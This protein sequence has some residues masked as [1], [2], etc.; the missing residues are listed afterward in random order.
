MADLFALVPSDVKLLI[1]SMT[2]DGACAGAMCCTNKSW[3]GLLKSRDAFWEQMFRAQVSDDE[4]DLALFQKLRAQEAL[5]GK[6]A[7]GTFYAALCERAFRRAAGA[8]VV[9]VTG[10]GAES[11]LGFA[12]EGA[13][14]EEAEGVP[15]LVSGK[16]ARVTLLRGQDVSYLTL[17]HIEDASRVAA[18][19]AVDAVVMAALSGSPSTP[20]AGYRMPVAVLVIAD[21]LS[22]MKR[23]DPRPDTELHTRSGASVVRLL[24]RS[25]PRL[26]EHGGCRAQRRALPRL[27]SAVRRARQEEGRIPLREASEEGEEEGEEAFDEEMRLLEEGHERGLLALLQWRRPPQALVGEVGASMRGCQLVDAIQSAR[28]LRWAPAL[29]AARE[30]L[31][32]VVAPSRPLLAAHIDLPAALWQAALRHVELGPS[33]ADAVYASSYALRWLASGDLGPPSAYLS[34]AKQATEASRPDIRHAG[35][36]LLDV[37]SLEYSDH[38]LSEPDYDDDNVEE[39]EEEKKMVVESPPKPV[40]RAP[41]PPSKQSRW[42]LPV[43]VAVLGYFSLRGARWLWRRHQQRK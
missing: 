40:I 28:S 37:A 14:R 26:V 11:V 3:N 31:E 6:E 13:V 34:L 9:G 16:G 42:W 7:F 12:R 36:M 19:L 5:S 39:E 29:H 8:C 20:N 10:E 2:Q 17:V 30:W 18:L 41:P 27:F 35:M 23:Q 4:S 43:V 15:H 25:L 21:S 22:P 38:G 1:V 32:A 33:M 24:R